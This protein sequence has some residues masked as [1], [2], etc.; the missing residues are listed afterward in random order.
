MRVAKP[1]HVCENFSDSNAAFAD[2][3]RRAPFVT[4]AGKNVS[5]TMPMAAPSVVC[6]F[7]RAYSTSTES[8]PTADESTRFHRTATVALRR[9]RTQTRRCAST[10]SDGTLSDA[11]DEWAAT[12][13]TDDTLTD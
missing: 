2:A 12:D 6:W 13:S 5:A 11:L 4:Y 7:H 10:S 3:I 9:C 1:A 8:D